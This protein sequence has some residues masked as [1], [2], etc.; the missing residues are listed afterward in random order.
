MGYSALGTVSWGSAP[1]IPATFSY[2]YQR[3][4]SNMQ[5]RIR[6]AIS[7]ISGGSYFGYPIYLG[8]SLDGR[9][10]VPGYTMKA[11]SPNRWSSAIIYDSGWI[12]VH[13]KVSGSTA[14]QITLYSGSGSSRNNTYH[15]T[16]PVSSYYVVPEWG[17]SGSGGSG[18]SGGNTPVV[19]NLRPSASLSAAVINDNAVVEGWG[20]CVQGLSKLRYSITAEAQG[21][22]TITSYNLSFAGQS[23][24]GAAGTSALI[25]VSGTLTP[26]ATVTDSNGRS[27]SVSGEPVQ[28]FAYNAP[29]IR[30]SFAWRCDSEG[31]E[32][33]A[34]AY[35]RVLCTAECSPLAGNNLLTVRVRYRPIGGEYGGYVTLTNGLTTTIGG[36]LDSHTSYEVEL[37]AI[38]TVGS[39]RV[40]SYTSST[41]A[42]ALHL[43]N[44]GNG[45]A[46]GKYAESDSL[47]CA[48]DANF[49]GDVAVAGELS[50]QALKVGGKSLLDL[51]YP[52]G[53]LYLST[54]ATDP[55]VLFGGGWTAIEGKFLLGASNDHAAG[56][57]G[58]ETSHTL[59][60]AEMPSHQHSVTVNG[61]GEHSH[62]ISNYVSVTS[63]SE[64]VAES[65]GGGSGGSR[66][67]YTDLDGFHTHNA[68]AAAAGGGTAFAIMPPYLAVY[69]W[70][71]IS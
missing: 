26:A 68:T 60:V 50:A 23:L 24:S 9:N 46:F 42:V 22:A 31:N 44:G 4:G 61:S 62:Y 3:S 29:R 39:E 12:T 20:L 19:E 25:G 59:T 56:T 33:D 57:T 71:R 30:S 18:G 1:V 67:L 49:S 58:G 69:M 10:V 38:D 40:I 28:V 45:A 54:S 66:T 15:Y 36:G 16:L 13:G 8:I 52:V 14:L 37:S 11:A 64:A 7:A 51:I 48:W 63:G 32:A 47:E 43:R 6:V 41:A 65:W 2:D 34:G 70:K 55:A 53:A 21:E 27:T 5:Y 17:E 35:L